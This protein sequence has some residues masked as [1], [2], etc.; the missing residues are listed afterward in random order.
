M[1]ESKYKTATKISIA[2]FEG[3]Q[4]FGYDPDYY[5]RMVTTISDV[6][7]QC[8][9]NHTGWVSEAA[10][11]LLS[12][13][14]CRE[15]Y[16]SRTQSAK[17][18]VDLMQKGIL[19]ADRIDRFEKFMQSRARVHFVT[20]KENSQLIKY[21]SD[22]NLTHW[23]QQYAA[24]GIKLTKWDKTS[25]KYVYRIDGREFNSAT[26]AAKAMGCHESTVIKRCNSDKWGTWERSAVGGEV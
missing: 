16:F 5:K 6:I 25:H 9:K 10:S 11:G 22:P 23:K 2:L 1:N 12:K 18:M 19:S 26:E 17:K 8:P 3:W 4:K 24:A 20:S 14:V 15:H 13:D 7:Y 21:Q